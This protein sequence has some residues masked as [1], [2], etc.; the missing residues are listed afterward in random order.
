MLPLDIEGNL[1]FADRDL[2]QIKEFELEIKQ[3]KLRWFFYQLLNYNKLDYID[4]MLNN[5][6]PF[7]QETNN[8]LAFEKVIEDVS[9]ALHL[10]D[11]DNAKN[12]VLNIKEGKYFFIKELFIQNLFLNI[13]KF[14]NISNY[15]FEEVLVFES[16]KRS[17]VQVAIDMIIQ[18][19]QYLYLLDTMENHEYKSLVSKLYLEKKMLNKNMIKDIKK[20]NKSKI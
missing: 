4:D 13:S 9:C 20:E 15:T 2:Q 14:V 19:P 8:K 18:N 3:K 6:I 7:Y 1:K 5:R 11:Y 12:T 17:I 10:E 16:N